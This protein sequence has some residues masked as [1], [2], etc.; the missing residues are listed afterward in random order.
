LCLFF[1]LSHLNLVLEF[2]KLKTL[3]RHTSGSNC[4]S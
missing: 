1:D 2:W 4:I 3:E